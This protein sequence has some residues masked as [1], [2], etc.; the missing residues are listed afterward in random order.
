MAITNF[1]MCN[2]LTGPGLSGLNIGTYP[3][4]NVLKAAKNAQICNQY[5]VWPLTQA[6]SGN[7]L[8]PAYGQIFPSGLFFGNPGVT[9]VYEQP[10]TAVGTSTFTVP[11]NVTQL[12]LR[13]WAGDGGGGG[14]TGGSTAGGSGGGGGGYAE[15]VVAVT[16]GQILT[17]NIG[18]A[19][20]AG[21]AGA[22]NGA[23]GGNTTITG[24]GVS[25][26]CTGGGGGIYA[27][28]GTPVAGGLGG[29]AS[30][31]SFTQ[32]GQNGGAGFTYGAGLAAT[33]LPGPGYGRIATNYGGANGVGGGNGLAGQVFIEWVAP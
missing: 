32:T 3:Y 29:N 9:Q 6:S 18:A 7:N 19:G 24:T 30:G 28:S 11:A 14:S 4:H 8:R 1:P 16:P 33:G 10:F 17:I 2:K 13:A 22:N 26:S 31:L 12:K 20:T 23:S 27:T 25:V 21:A 5:G 15:G